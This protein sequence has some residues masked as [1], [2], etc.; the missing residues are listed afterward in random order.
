MTLPRL[1]PMPHEFVLAHAGRIGLF[2][3][4]RVAQSQRQRLIERLAERH[5]EG[6]AAFSLLEQMATI[7]GMNASDYARQ[8]SLLPTLRV[9]ER[10]TAPALHGSTDRQGIAKLVG[11][12]LHTGRVHLCPRC[13]AEDLSHWG[14][15][16]FRR[17]HNLVGVEC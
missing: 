4:G 6:A 8:H 11:S 15:S 1:A 3:C 7:G 9:A 12:R 16:W 5:C 13:V 14:F 10:G 17:T 2:F